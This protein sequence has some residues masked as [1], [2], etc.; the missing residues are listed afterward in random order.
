[1]FNWTVSSKDY[2]N[3]TAAESMNSFGSISLHA[4][5]MI[6]L[7]ALDWPSCHLMRPHLE[8][9]L[10]ELG[11]LREG[12][13]VAEPAVSSTTLPLGSSDMFSFMSDSCIHCNEWFLGYPVSQ[14][15]RSAAVG[16]VGTVGTG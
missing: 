3:T 13:A 15:C 4:P 5:M 14:V 2:S 9:T 11:L 12:P 6:R 8:A 16:T 7:D 10:S 1:M